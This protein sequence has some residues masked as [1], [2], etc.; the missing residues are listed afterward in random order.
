MDNIYQE[1]ILEHYQH[2][3]NYGKLENASA[4]ESLENPS[5]GDII[6]MFVKIQDDIVKDISF[7]G[8]GCA[9][10]Q[11]SASLLTDATKGKPKGKILQMKRD[12]IQQLLGV[13]L[14][15][16]RLKCA[17]LPLETLHKLLRKHN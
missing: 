6:K 12:D 1:M 2:P 14:G 10:S 5:C 13:E 11:A 17:L 16:T 4:A 8:A 9:I 7:E 15:P 3:H